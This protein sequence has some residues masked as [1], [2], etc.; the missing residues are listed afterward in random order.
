MHSSFAVEP[1]QPFELDGALSRTLSEPTVSRNVEE[2]S[3]LDLL[4]LLL[5]DQN[6]EDIS[7][8]KSAPPVRRSFSIG[9]QPNKLNMVAVSHLLI[10]WSVSCSSLYYFYPTMEN[11]QR[12][13]CLIGPFLLLNFYGRKHYLPPFLFNLHRFCI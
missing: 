13:I 6:L 7:I 9:P 10:T 8:R 5:L 4:L 12:C 1:L 2:N 3:D 11:S